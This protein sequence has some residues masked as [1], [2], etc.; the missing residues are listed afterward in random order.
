MYNQ[1]N[2]LNLLYIILNYFYIKYHA[3]YDLIIDWGLDDLQVILHAFEKVN[4]V[5]DLILF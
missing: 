3:K 2:T 4:K 1:K 5:V